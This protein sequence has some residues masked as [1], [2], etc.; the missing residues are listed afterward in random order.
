VLLRPL[1]FRDPGRLVLLTERTQALPVLSASWQNYQ[2]WRDQS[3]SFE[4]VG[5]VRTTGMTLTGSGGPERL[6]AQM[7]SSNI[8]DLLGVTPALGRPFSANDDKTGGVAL[9]GYALWQRRFGGDPAVVGRAVTLDNRSYTV[10][11]V[12]AP[13]FEVLQQAPDVMVP[14]EPWARTLPNDRSWHPGILPI[15]RLKPGVTLEQARADMS[16]LA[17]RLH[18]QYEDSNIAL[19]ANVN[20]MQQQLVQGVRPAL[21]ALLGAVG[22]VLL[23]ACVNVANLLLARASARQREI[24]IRT[25]IGASRARVIRQLLTESVL[26][27]L[28]GAALGVLVAMAAMDSLLE[29][30]STSVAGIT[31]IHVNVAV[32][33]FT[34][35]LA[36]AAGVLFGLAPALHAGRTDLRSALSESER[37]AVSRGASR[38]RSALVVSEV[39]IAM[40]LLVGAGLLIRSFERL[41][42]VSLGFATDHILIADLPVSANAY[43]KPVDRMNFF[44]AVV[45]R[46]STLPGVRSAGA[47]SYLPVSGGGMILHFNIQGRPPKSPTNYIMANYRAVSASYLKTLGIPLVKGRWLQDSDRENTPAVVVINETMARTYFGNESA[48]GKHLQIGALPD[49]QVPWMEVVGIVGDVKQGLAAE[50]PSEMYVPY[51]QANE[52]LPVTFLSVVL[53]TDADPALIASSVRN[54]VH[55]IDANQ[56]VVNVRTMEENLA[57]AMSQPKFRTL[58]LSIFAGLGLLIA[59]VGIYGVM[60]YSTTQRTREIGVRMA[61]GSTPEAIFRLVLGEGLRLTVIGVL[62]GVAASIA[63]TRYLSSLLFQIRSTDPLTMAAVAVLLL[64]AAAVACY[65]PARRATRVDPMIAVHYE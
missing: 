25:A 58:L 48:L 3:H 16:T 37:G 42:R 43:P 57:A 21:L 29:L 13:R 28:C 19:D 26:L 63:A 64:A 59:C 11:G 38:L 52:V 31:N 5:A 22:F 61:L 20:I 60:A 46:V 34:T 33:G 10:V 40:L 4:A 1:P 65:L 54:V 12:L 56:P 47:A 41:S 2:D 45:E 55:E 35:A 17:K 30:G 39:G 8:F 9:I 32:L 27:S 6:Q 51:R 7:A 18:Q 44:D 49:P 24:A 36:V 53:R 14:L 50:P 62:V 23:I 15:A